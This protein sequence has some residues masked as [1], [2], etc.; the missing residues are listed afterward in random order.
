MSNV[1]ETMMRAAQSLDREAEQYETYLAHLNSELE[2]TQA[3]L[4]QARED[5]ASIR[6]GIEA[7]SA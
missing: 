7:P 2:T 4:K 5:A 3:K 1:N 6:E